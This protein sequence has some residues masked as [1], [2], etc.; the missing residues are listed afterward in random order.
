MHFKD[1]FDR[2]AELV[3][4]EGT[5]FLCSGPD[6]PQGPG[7]T[8]SLIYYRTNGQLDIL[9]SCLKMLKSIECQKNYLWSCVEDGGEKHDG[10]REEEQ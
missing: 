9:N 6:V 1:F 8:Q 10:C 4:F 2:V 7:A 5:I 3:L